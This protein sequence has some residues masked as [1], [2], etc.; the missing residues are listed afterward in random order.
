MTEKISTRLAEIVGA[1]P[2]HPGIR[3][4]E[5]GCGT[6]VAARAVLRRGDDGHVLAIDRSGNAIAQAKAGSHA[7]M[8][9]GRL[10]FRQIS[11]EELVLDNGEKPYDRAFAVRRTATGMPSS[12]TVARRARARRARA[13]R[14][15]EGAGPRPAPPPASGRLA[16]GTHRADDR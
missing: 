13:Q 14:D 9:T 15:R 3:V 7:E 12:R 1:L 4:L 11:V 5:I 10:E 16:D 2:M 8:A 6:G